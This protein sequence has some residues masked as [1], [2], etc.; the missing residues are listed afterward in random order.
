MPRS[1]SASFILISPDMI[2]LSIKNCT[3]TTTERGIGLEAMSLYE[4]LDGA[5]GWRWPSRP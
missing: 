4:V 5:G 2:L 3:I 1:F